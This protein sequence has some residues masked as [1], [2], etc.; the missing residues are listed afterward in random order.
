MG[1]RARHVVALLAVVAAAGACATAADG[2]GGDAGFVYTPDP[3][4][5]PPIPPPRQPD[6]T[7]DASSLNVGNRGRDGGGTGVDAGAR[8][9]GIDAGKPPPPPVDASQPPPVDANEP[10]PVDANQPPPDD[11]SPPPDDA[12]QPP[13]V[14]ANPPPPMDSGTVAPPNACPTP[15]GAGDLATVELMIE[16]QSGTGDSGEWIEIQNVHPDCAV[17]LNGLS[18]S[19]ASS[20]AT[21]T[22]T[23]DL[24]LPPNGLLVVADSTDPSIDHQ[25]P[26]PI[27][28]PW[29]VSADALA[30]PGDTVTLTAIGGATVDSL[31]YPAFVLYVAVSISFP[32]D[33]A[34]SDRASWARW[35]YSA[36]VWT[37]GFEGTPNADNTDV[38]CY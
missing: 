7:G 11:A 17:N 35:S 15:L 12:S 6:Y 24:W 13:P 29:S 30:N 1:L 26:S 20:G 8:P 36:H 18:V 22:V 19:V 3:G 28:I 21:A 33:C 5:N 37:S 31:T 32:A 10:P 9:P 16:S 25:I 4:N 14:D 34:W 38:T 27:V 23:S 2:P